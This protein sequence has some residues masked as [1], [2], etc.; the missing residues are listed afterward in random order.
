[1]TPFD[2]SA[3]FFRAAII[4]DAFTGSEKRYEMWQK[5]SDKPTSLAASDN[6]VSVNG[7]TG[8]G[9]ELDVSSLAFVTDV[10]VELQL[11]YIPVL[12]ATLSPPL[13]DGRKFLDS[14]LIEYSI[15]ALE[16]Q[17]GYATGPNN[18]LRSPA[19]TGIISA[20]EVSYGSDISITLN[21]VGIG[22]YALAA[23]NQ[24]GAE[25]GAKTRA[26][27]SEHVDSLVQ[28]LGIKRLADDVDDVSS[29]ALSASVDVVAAS[30]SYLA[31]IYELARQSGCWVDMSDNGLRLVSIKKLVLQSAKTVLRFYDF[32]GSLGKAQG[33]YTVFPIVSVSSESNGQGY[34]NNWSKKAVRQAMDRTTKEQSEGEIDPSKKTASQ[35]KNAQ[36][37]PKD[38]SSEQSVRTDQAQNQSDA[39]AADVSQEA[40]LDQARLE[41]TNGSGLQL[42]VESLG[43][44][45]ILP[46]TN[47]AVVGLG[48]RF[49]GTYTVFKVQHKLSSSGYTTS[50]SLVQSSTKLTAALQKAFKVTQFGQG[51]E[52][53]G[54]QTTSVNDPSN[55]T[56]VPVETTAP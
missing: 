11:G 51:N 20:P 33:D 10:T 9:A 29:K 53:A 5:N 13:E 43:I 2:Y 16:I 8:S 38:K 54:A 24:H 52:Q 17:F 56:T 34:L 49:D 47:V 39:G 50:L 48:S 28:K 41:A 12:S 46:A 40:A 44:P 45:D 23:T 26:T 4:S 21:A 3:P 18:G 42:E 30:K 35:D 22:G 36:T 27:R 19:F 14:K 1:M 37:V 55:S 25:A 32:P 31:I 7:L 15:S 6:Y